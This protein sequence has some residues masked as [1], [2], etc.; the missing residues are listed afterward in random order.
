L[1]GDD[2]AE[3]LHG[4]ADVLV[5][6]VKTHAGLRCSGQGWSNLNVE[7]K[8]LIPLSEIIFSVRRKRILL[9]PPK[10]MLEKK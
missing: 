2:Q 9:E 6:G 3:L 1:R 7:L 10:W 8:I 5:T 4:E